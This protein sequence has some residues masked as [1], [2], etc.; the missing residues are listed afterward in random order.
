MTTVR[1]IHSHGHLTGFSCYGHSGY[2]E[3][4][5]D[6]V[7]AAVTSAIRLVEC[8]VNDVLHAEARVSVEECTAAIS[9][10]LADTCENRLECETVLQGLLLYM[11]ELSAE[12]PDYLTILEV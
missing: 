10:R 3:E 1:F 9:L 6:I 12:N 4:G 11:R 2:A 5:A 8:T 7:C